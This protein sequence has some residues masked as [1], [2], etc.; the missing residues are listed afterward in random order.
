MNQMSHA[1]AASADNLTI[2]VA[3]DF[4]RYP[5][6]RFRKD[7]DYSAEEFRDDVLVPAVKSA[8]LRG[9][10]VTVILDGV[11]GY[12]VSF[13]EE[14]FGGLVRLNIVSPPILQRVFS[15]VAETPL[16]EIY[17]KLA[18]KYMNEAWAA[19]KAS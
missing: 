13:L 10:T 17:Q 15:V 1:L 2:R 12:A 8:V 4:S 16:Y 18:E 6:G 5:G 19:A 11:A 14:A 9:G 3:R 7:G